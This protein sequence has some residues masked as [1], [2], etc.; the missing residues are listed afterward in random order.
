M[1][2]KFFFTVN[3]TGCIAHSTRHLIVDNT[4]MFAQILGNIMIPD[5]PQREVS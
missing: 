3:K 5:N 2:Y 1:Q 4:A